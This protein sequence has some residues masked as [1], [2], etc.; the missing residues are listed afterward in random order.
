VGEWVERKK[1][2]I[3]GSAGVEGVWAGCGGV[4]NGRRVQQEGGT[5]LIFKSTHTPARTRNLLL[6]AAFRKYLSEGRKE[7]GRNQ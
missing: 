2:G 6:A 5:C 1:H 3:M 4:G 7:K